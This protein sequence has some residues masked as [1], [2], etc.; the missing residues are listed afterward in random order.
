MLKENMPTDP[1]EIE[2]LAI[3]ID[4][5][6]HSLGFN[7]SVYTD[8][9]YMN[10]EPG[11]YEYG[12]AAV[13]PW[14]D[15]SDFNV[16]GIVWSNDLD[17]NMTGNLTINGTCALGLDQ[18]AG[19]VVTLTNNNEDYTYEAELD[20]EGAWSTEEFRKGDYTMTVNLPGYLALVANG[21][22][23]DTVPAD[24]LVMN[25]WTAEEINIEFVEDY[26]PVTWFTVSSTGFAR[27]SDMLP[28]DRVAQRYHVLCDEIFQGETENNYMFLNTD[29]LVEG[30]TYTA[31]V[32]VIYE[33]GMSDFVTA[34][35]T[36]MSCENVGTQVED[37]EGTVDLADV[38]LTWAG[39]NGSGVVPPPPGGATTFTEGFESGL[40]TGWTVVDG[41]NDGWTWCL[42]SDIP[43]T[44]TYYTMTLDWYRTGTNAICSGSY[45]NGVGAL[46]PNE[47]LV[48]DQVNLAAG[49][50]FSFWAAATDASYPADHFGVFVSDDATNW[51]SVQE[52]TLTGKKGGND[53]GRASRDGKG[54]RLGTWYNYSVDLSSYAGQKYIAIRHFNC[55]DQYIMCVDDIELSA[56]SKDGF[57]LGTAGHGFG[58]AN[59]SL[60][61]DG[62]WYYYDNGVN[63]DAIGTGGGNFWWGIMLPAGTYEGTSVTKVAAYDYMAMTGTASIYQGGTT[64]PAGSALG[65]V[66]VTFTESN[67][68][69]EFTFAEPVTIN[70][71]QNVWVVFYNGSGATYPAAVCS[72]TGD[73]N[74]RWVS[75]DGTTWEDLAGY[76]LNYTFMVRAYIEQ[77]GV[78]PPPTPGA[79]AVTPNAFNIFMDGELIGATTDT[80]FTYTCDDDLEHQYC[81]MYF[82]ANYNVSCAECI[83][84]TADPL[85]VGQYNV[86]S[87]IY[88]NPTNGN[89]YINT[90]ANMKSISIINVM[91]QVVYNKATE[92]TETVI[93]MAQFGNGIYMVS[94]V[95]ENGT[96][97][98]RI[99]VNK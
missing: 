97:V 30:E 56:G 75:L 46:T 86:V 99:I 82:D 59:N 22:D 47:Y 85:G 65:T 84:I 6:D 61:D 12:I 38:T 3:Q 91:G 36:Y 90:N 2:A 41:N 31:A 77:G 15:R 58:L 93:D 1:A 33:T 14:V 26:A 64:A 54:A 10:L 39:G 71:S 96:S 66:N 68:F 45:I 28:Q 52:W 20:E 24:G 35:F 94:I 8:M 51:T 89:L 9:S 11:V 70:P 16:T 21:A 92:G 25:L 79:V 98:N 72:N 49:S 34:D 44:W 74:G 19:A 13:Y 73:A 29:N 23:V 62:N 81:V 78:T 48:T 4:E 95:T 57:V 40:P 5:S 67:D 18:I 80:T 60:S 43:S 63:E 69:V 17:H 53:G 37:L 7:D 32:A 87:A 42:T 88:P 55:N 83:N 76:G 27:W 50:T